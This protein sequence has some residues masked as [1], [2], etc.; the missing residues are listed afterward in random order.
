MSETTKIKI[1][2]QPKIQN[3]KKTVILQKQKEQKQELIVDK[4]VVDDVAAVESTGYNISN[5]RN[6]YTSDSYYRTSRSLINKINKRFGWEDDILP[7]KQYEQNFNKIIEFIME[8]YVIR[9]H[10]MLSVKLS[11]IR[12][13]L[14][15]YEYDGD[16]MHKHIELKDIQYSQKQTGENWS[17]IVQLLDN[18]IIHCHHPGGRIVASAYKYGYLV[19]MTD[20]IRTK[21]DQ[22]D[23][24]YNYLDLDKLHWTIQGDI[25]KNRPGT[26]IS[27]SKEFVDIV[28]TNI[29]KGSV[30]LISKKGGFQYTSPV[31]M[32]HLGLSG[33]NLN[34]IKHAMSEIE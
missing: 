1:K 14:K 21:V 4:V 23:E 10:E 6:K 26:V 7:V 24:G 28:K 20:M 32:K 11:A 33:F 9:N 30:W 34:Q 27:V 31:A 17:S 29:R 2:I 25:D 13:P 19:S 3:P 12:Y 15:L 16:F 22:F 5:L 8:S 18:Y